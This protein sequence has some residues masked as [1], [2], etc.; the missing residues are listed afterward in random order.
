MA[1]YFEQGQYN[2]SI[3]KLNKES[4]NM[5]YL[6]VLKKIWSE[7]LKTNL[8]HIEDNF[9]SLGGDSIRSMMAVSKLEELLNIK[10]E[11]SFFY[12]YPT[13]VSQKHYLEQ[14]LLGNYIQSYSLTLVKI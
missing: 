11:N 5:D 4:H 9:F 6:L 14:Y 3:V 1:K 7:V 12:K 13:L 2:K 10:L 8:I